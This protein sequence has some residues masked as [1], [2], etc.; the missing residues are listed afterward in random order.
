M[1]DLVI[2]QNI[3]VDGVVSNDSSW[4]GPAD[5]HDLGDVT[6]VL[7]AQARASDA[8]LVG[9]IT[10]EEMRGYWPQQTDDTTGVTDH[11]NRVAKYVVSST[12]DD[13][14][15][16]GTTVLRGPLAAEVQALKEAPGSDIV[17]TGSIQLCHA[18]I[19]ADLV[20]EFRLFTYPV[21]EGRGR[22]LF[23]DRTAVPALRLVE[24]RGFRSG[25]VL[26]RYRADAGRP[27]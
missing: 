27:G 9:R 1:R 17:V 7:M 22:R 18:L 16:E 4:F 10:F 26:T 2:T 15:W 20:D 19:D 21:V 12:L 3:T 5:D 13:P 8:F 6:E 11:L 23:A 24:V 25:L 14:R